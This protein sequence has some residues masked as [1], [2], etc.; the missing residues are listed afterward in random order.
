[1]KIEVNGTNYDI[2]IIGDKAMVNG[3]EMGVKLNEDEIRIGGDI[4][5]LDF[6]E[7]GE[8]SLMIINGMTYVVSRSLA[9]NSLFKEVKSPMSGK[10]VGV[11]AKARSEVKKGQV[12]VVLEAMK[13]EN[14][15]K[16]HV[17]GRIREIKV[18]EGQS[19]KMGQVLV[20][21]E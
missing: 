4:F 21:F 11:F 15:I 19:V 7:E 14:Q 12:L 8:P 9:D 20:I 16:S 10:I 6:V 3:K 1:M 2:E 5:R 13:M 18:C 17:N